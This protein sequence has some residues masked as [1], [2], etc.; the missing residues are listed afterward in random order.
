MSDLPAEDPIPLP[1]MEGVK[2]STCPPPTVMDERIPSHDEQ[3][4]AAPNHRPA[5]DAFMP[6]PDV[7]RTRYALSSHKVSCFLMSSFL[8][9]FNGG[10]PSYQ[11][12]PPRGA[13]AV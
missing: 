4:A 8:L 5:Q 11:H 10:L 7:E 6:P 9:Q 3:S 1:P 2:S 13:H 12:P